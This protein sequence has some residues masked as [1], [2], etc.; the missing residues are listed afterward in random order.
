MLLFK[1]VLL[2]VLSPAFLLQTVLAATPQNPLLTVDA[3]YVSYN[4]VH[5]FNRTTL[6]RKWSAMQGL[7]T[8]EPVM[9][10]K[11]LYV[12]SPQG[13]YALDPDTGQQVW[14]I[15]ESRTI[16]SPTVARQIYAGSL[17]GALYSIN[18]ASGKIIWRQQFAG[19]IYS[20]VVQPDSNQLWTGGQDHEAFALSINDGRQMHRIALNQESVF[21]PVDLQNNQIAFNLFN[22]QTAIINT[23]TAKIETWLNGSTQPKNLIFDDRFIYRS[24]RDGQLTAFDRNS[25]RQAWQKSVVGR[26]LT[27][28]PSST[29]Q[30]LLSDLG[31]ILVLFD[32]QKHGEIWRKSIPGNW[33]SPIQIDTE[34]II[35]FHSNNL[36]PN[37]LSAVKI[38]AQ[39][40]N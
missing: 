27:I 22:G 7:Q 6:E 33:F 35:Y 13:L 34:N 17:H 36:Q 12:G 3:L 19:W 26:D 24:S 29:S 14:R 1:W 25:Y 9:G 30:I 15:E 32:P 4:G 40:P 16:F 39:P 2:L 28:H 31:K 10:N 20:P 11:L 37:M 18:P 5:K 21:S 8:F 23:V 38:S